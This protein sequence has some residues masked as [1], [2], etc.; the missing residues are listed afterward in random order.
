MFEVILYQVDLTGRGLEV[1]RRKTFNTYSSA[2]QW[3]DELAAIELD[4]FEDSEEFAETGEY[5]YA[6]LFYEI[7]TR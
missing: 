6:E 1:W 4:E 3:V 5:P 7:I 2:L